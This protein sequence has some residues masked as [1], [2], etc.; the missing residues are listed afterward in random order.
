MMDGVR[1]VTVPA[2]AIPAPS[3]TS[4]APKIPAVVVFRIVSALLEL[5]SRRQ[6]A[7]P[8]RQSRSQ[9]MT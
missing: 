6:I 5:F 2:S 3:T 1:T 4:I 7:M 9:F 8:R